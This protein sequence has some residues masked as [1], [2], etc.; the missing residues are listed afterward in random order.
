MGS[1]LSA[2]GLREQQSHTV[3]PIAVEVQ[4]MEQQTSVARHTYVGE[5]EEK[6]SVAL[7]AQAAGRVEQIYIERGAR[8]SA[9]QVLLTI[10]STQ[11]AN[12]RRSAEAVLRQAEDGYARACVLYKE[13]GITEQKR[14]EIESQLMQARSMYA[15]ASR[16][17]DECRVVAPVAGIVAECRAKV[18]ETVAPGLPLLTIMNMDGFVVRFHVPETEIAR[19][20]IGDKAMMQVAAIHADELPVV[21]TEKSL[22]PNKLAHSYALVAAVQGK[23]NLLPGMMA[24][25]TLASDIVTGYV[26]PQ[27]CIQMLPG[28]AKVWVTNNNTALRK[29]IEVGQYVT[30]GVLVTAG[31]EQGD[32]IITK[33]YQKLWQGAE[34]TY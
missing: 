26:L 28:G 24:K 2:C 13:G 4:T 27:H 7:S 20:K 15:S 5:I 19:V 29:D 11:A 9:G 32:K 1:M 18:G 21:I 12:A 30:D 16:M 17:V 33:G 25:V 31:I 14:V 10:D 34:I 3:R 6:S 23:T 22:I 8:V